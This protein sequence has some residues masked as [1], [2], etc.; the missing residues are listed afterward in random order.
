MVD[1][2]KSKIIHDSTFKS[3]LP[4]ILWSVL[5]EWKL[6]NQTPLCWNNFHR[7]PDIFQRRKAR[8]W[9]FYS[10]HLSPLHLKCSQECKL[11]CGS[12][13]ADF[14]NTIIVDHFKI[15]SHFLLILHSYL[16]VPFTGVYAVAYISVFLSSTSGCCSRYLWWSLNFFDLSVVKKKKKN[17]KLNS[18][19][20]GLICLK[21]L[22]LSSIPYF[23]L[24]YI[25][26]N[27]ICI[28]LLLLSHSLDC[29]YD[30]FWGLLLI[31]GCY[32]ALI[33]VIFFMIY[34][35]SSFLVQGKKVLKDFNIAEAAKGTGKE[36]I[37]NFIT[38]V[39]DNTLEIHLQWGGKGTNAVPYRGV[40]G[41]L[42]SAIS[43]T[44]SMYM[45]YRDL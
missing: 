26:Q 45:L 12:L 7:W 23:H 27:C 10:G 32:I 3:S 28:I 35:V 18:F 4:Q 40:H 6:Y 2:A 20:L 13:C 31:P 41:P 11:S 22:M 1:D 34:L 39:E 29:K 37:K 38:L 15:N 16:S 44:P 24:S 36:I 9:C 25:L 14:H 42:I 5:A 21:Y 19:Q 33:K 30:L 8:I 17:V 43:V